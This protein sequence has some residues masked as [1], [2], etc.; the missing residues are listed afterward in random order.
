MCPLF[1]GLTLYN[2]MLYTTRNMEFLSRLQMTW[3]PREI[4]DHFKLYY[5]QLDR[6]GCLREPRVLVSNELLP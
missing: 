6:V 1:V 4:E 5:T 3:N 2:L